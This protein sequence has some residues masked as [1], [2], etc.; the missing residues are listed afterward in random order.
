MDGEKTI[1]LGEEELYWKKDGQ[2]KIKESFFGEEQK[3]EE[4]LLQEAF[5]RELYIQENKEE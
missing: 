1:H 3:E 5:D 4:F 2:F